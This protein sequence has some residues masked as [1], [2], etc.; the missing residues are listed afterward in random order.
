MLSRSLDVGSGDR[1]KGVKTGPLY[2]TLS[3]MACSLYSSGN[4]THTRYGYN[5]LAFIQKSFGTFVH[6]NDSFLKFSGIKCIVL[7]CEP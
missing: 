4:R 1:N 6:V 7:L 2:I 3:S 5:S